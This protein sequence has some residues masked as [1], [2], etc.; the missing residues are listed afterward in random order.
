MKA[1][2][3]MTLTACFIVCLLLWIPNSCTSSD[4]KSSSSP[5]KW[6]SYKE[7][8]A[9]GKKEKK[10]M[11]I[12]FYADW[13]GFCKKMDNETFKDTPVVNYLNENFISIK[14]NSDKEQQIAR[15]FYVQGLPTMWFLSYEEERLTSLPGYVPADRM[16][17]L[18]KF[19]HTESYK[20]MKFSEFLKGKM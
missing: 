15:D 2:Y 12:N 6:Y 17:P 20:K 8:L 5:V 11:L 13:C 4:K 14:V 7:G 16:L 18:L 10:N 1:K 3:S 9:A 19:I